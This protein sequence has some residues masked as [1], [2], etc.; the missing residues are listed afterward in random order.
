MK[1]TN[2]FSFYPRVL[3]DVRDVVMAESEALAKAHSIGERDRMKAKRSF[4]QNMDSVHGSKLAL[5]ELR[6]SHTIGFIIR[7][8]E[9]PIERD[10]KYKWLDEYHQAI[11]RGAHGCVL[12]V[13][14]PHF[15]Q[16]VPFAEVLVSA[17][18]DLLTMARE[19]NKDLRTIWFNQDESN[20]PKFVHD[21][22]ALMTRQRYKLSVPDTTHEHVAGW[23][24]L[25]GR[26]GR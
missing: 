20:S 9:L 25:L 2:R 12:G 13:D 4:W 26:L 6:L 17:D 24:Q 15:R 1:K 21:G 16:L 22:Q 8:G 14:T 5:D 7:E 18:Q 3:I 11:V 19:M 23:S 10:T